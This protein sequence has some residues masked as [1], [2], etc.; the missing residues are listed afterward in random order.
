MGKTSAKKRSTSS[1]LQMSMNTV[2]VRTKDNNSRGTI[3]DSV[4]MKDSREDNDTRKRKNS[5][6]NDKND[7]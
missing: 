2:R 3:G 6:N 1:M 4:D 7:N 5:V